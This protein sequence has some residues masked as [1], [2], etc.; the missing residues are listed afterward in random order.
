VRTHADGSLAFKLAQSKDGTKTTDWY[1][2]KGVIT[3]E[4]VQKADGYNSTTVYTSGVKTS[5]F[6]TN[7]DRTQ[8]NYT[9]NITGQSYTTQV[10]HLDAAG[11]VTS[12]VRTHADGTLDY[13]QVINS[14]GSSAVSTY[15]AAGV[16]ML[17]TD[18]H[19]DH[20]KDV[21][22]YNITGQSYTTEH[23]S[24]DATGFL[25]SIVRTHSDGSLAFQLAQTT[26]GTKTTDTYNATG[27]ITSEVV[28]KADG[29][30]STTLY[31]SGVK[32]SAYV[33]N[34]DHT[35]DNYVFNVTG[36]SYTTQ[37]QHLD[38]TGKVTAVER[39]HADG[40]FD[41]TQVI[42]TDG[43]KVTDLYDSTGN[44]TQET[45]NNAS[46]TTDVF[47]FVVSGSPG[48]VEHDFYNSAG[49]LQSIDV[50]NTNGT[51]TITAAT[52][53]VTLSGGT[54]NDIYWSAGSTTMVNSGNDLIYNFV[55]GNGTNHDTIQIASA[56]AADYS[57]LQISQNGNDTLVQVSASDSVLLKNVLASHLTSNDFL[58][59]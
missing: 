30:S 48:A 45:I 36:Q 4:V 55:A 56:L 2:A 7:A 47:K 54:G 51:H 59:V 10:Q 35:Q 52:T 19:A 14:D 49:K 26:D 3:S 23:D 20:S 18:V 44:K 16:K 34:A 33:T 13:T 42:N 28:Q 41:F 24:Y 31:T 11:K 8:D 32:S 12:V 38:A 58:F 43:S 27:V 17:E 57:H 21:Y 22:T 46:G 37:H 40:T 1:D 50:L 29:Y 53:G 39:T 9:Y 6:V 5:A 15:N 25:T